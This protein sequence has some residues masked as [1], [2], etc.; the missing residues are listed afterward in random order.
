MKGE[1]IVASQQYGIDLVGRPLEDTHWQA[2]AQSGF[3]ARDFTID[4]AA[5]TAVCPQGKTSAGW[6]DTQSRGE[7]VIQV[8]FADRECQACPCRSAC[9]R[10]EKRGRRLQLRPQP[11]HE[12]LVAARARAATEAF[13]ITY[14]AR[15]GIEGT[16]NQAIRRCGMRQVAMSDWESASAACDNGGG[17]ELCAGGGLVDG[18]APGAHPAECLCPSHGRREP[19]TNSPVVSFGARTGRDNLPRPAAWA[20]LCEPFG[21]ESRL[22]WNPDLGRPLTVC[23]WYQGWRR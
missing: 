7:A 4:W 17:A 23:Q 8:V 19:R 16:H 10:A 13:V 18:N 22:S 14:A 11:V 20:R 12:A 21:P 3:A 9:T 2:Q 15:A 1:E 6:Y 5:R